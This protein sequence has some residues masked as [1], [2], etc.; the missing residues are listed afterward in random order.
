ML[1]QIMKHVRDTH[2]WVLNPGC[3]LDTFLDHLD[4]LHAFVLPPEADCP[5]YRYVQVEARRREFGA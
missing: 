4:K 1:N 3:L 2:P 5:S